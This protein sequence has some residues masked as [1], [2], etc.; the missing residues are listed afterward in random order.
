MHIP[1]TKMGLILL[2]DQ[3][4]AGEVSAACL[5][6]LGCLVNFGNKKYISKNVI[7][8]MQIVEEMF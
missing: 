6:G 7:L 1:H 4:N 2:K 8:I 5:K 3:R